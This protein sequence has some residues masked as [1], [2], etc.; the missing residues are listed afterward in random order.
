MQIVGLFITLQQLKLKVVEVTQTKP[1]PFWNGVP[2]ASWW[3]WF[4][5][6]HQEIIIWLAE[7]LKVFKVKGL[8]KEAC[9]TFYSNL[10]NMYTHH[11][12]ALDHIWNSNET[13]IQVGCQSSARV[14]ARRGSW[15]VYNTILKSWEWLIV[16][17]VINVARATLLAFYIFKGSR[18]QENYIW[19]C[20]P[21]ICM[22]MNNFFGWQLTIL[23]NGWFFFCRYIL[24]G[25]YEYNWHLLNLDGHGFHATIQA[26]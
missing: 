5:N 22:V 11:K 20:R 8:T 26:L 6:R 3:Y 1:T 2:G 18:M 9:H 12:Y 17:C 16:N 13:I 24:R 7:G 23:N 15:N 14:L 10:E 19:D 25:V 21:G 4:I